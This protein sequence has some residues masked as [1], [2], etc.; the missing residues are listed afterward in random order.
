[1][2]WVV[3]MKLRR[4]IVKDHLLKCWTKDRIETHFFKHMEFQ[5]Q[6]VIYSSLQIFH[7]D[8]WCFLS[9]R[10]NSWVIEQM[11]FIAAAEIRS[12]ITEITAMI[13]YEFPT[14]NPSR[15]T[16]DFKN[17]SAFGWRNTHSIH[18]TA[19]SNGFSFWSLNRAD[20]SL[21]FSEYFGFPS[22]ASNFS[23]T[24]WVVIVR[25]SISSAIPN[26]MDL[27]KFYNGRESEDISDNF[28]DKIFTEFW[29]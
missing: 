3:C 13:S 14:M 5:C 24:V 20:S 15:R 8:F 23:F 1:M 11:I 19:L 10:I 26:W 21:T 28:H 29:S 4:C 22:I 16:G 17:S 6:K 9:T 12:K 25:K 27:T 7:S 2:I 18:Q